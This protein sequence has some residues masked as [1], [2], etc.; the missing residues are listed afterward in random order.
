MNP[1]TFD[2]LIPRFEGPNK[3]ELIA[4]T[5]KTQDLVVGE[6]IIANELASLV[7]LRELHAGE[8]LIK[9]GAVDSVLYFVFSGLLSVTING[10]DVAVRGPRQHVGE[11]SLLESTARRSATV[12]ATEPS[13][14][15]GISHND[16][17]AIANRHPQLWQRIAI[18][19]SRRLKERSKHYPQPR[20][21]PVLFLGSS[22]ENIE[23]TR[24]IQN[25]FAHD[26]FVIKPW[27]INVFA[28]SDT[29]IESLI[30]V[31]HES[32]FGVLI[33]HPVDL[34][35]SRNETSPSPRDNVVF[36]LG[37]FMGRI[38]RS[39]CFLIKERGIDVKIPT[40]LI[41]VKPLE[42]QGGEPATLANRLAPVCNE[43]RA[44]VKRLGP[45]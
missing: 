31:L 23:I 7:V 17:S 35:I 40:D 42:Y 34:T 26:P 37:L 12:T 3:T 9:Q 4:N 28:P 18:E 30:T 14:V 2:S 16:F 32:D 20:N 41:G 10:R 38:G 13:L 15:A 43:L 19:L 27:T 24:E 21:Q 8:V 6:D 45:I 36:E 1:A 39:R 44:L 25:A 29:P 11:M 22:A 33:I 5:L